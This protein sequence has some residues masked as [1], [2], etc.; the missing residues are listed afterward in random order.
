MRQSARLGLIAAVMSGAV[1]TGPIITQAPANATSRPSSP[2]G[3]KEENSKVT[4][5]KEGSPVR[6][7]SSRSEENTQGTPRH[8]SQEKWNWVEFY[9]AWG[10]KAGFTSEDSFKESLENI[11][12]RGNEGAIMALIPEYGK[13]P[14]FMRVEKRAD[15]QWYYDHIGGEY[16]KNSSAAPLDIETFNRGSVVSAWSTDLKKAKENYLILK[17]SRSQFGDDAVYT[18]PELRAILLG[19]DG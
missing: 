6:G 18:N 19:T 10:K 7:S 15:N 9:A 8:T 12:R 4:Q 5:K 16:L 3:A 14:V 17:Y 11:A 2:K 1:I 13:R